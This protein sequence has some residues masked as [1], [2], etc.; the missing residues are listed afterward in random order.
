MYEWE[1]SWTCYD[2]S[3]PVNFSW[4]VILHVTSHSKKAIWE[5]AEAAASLSAKT[6]VN[7]WTGSNKKRLTQ[8]WECPCGICCTGFTSWGIIP[9]NHC[10]DYPDWST[11]AKLN[12]RSK[13]KVDHLI[14]SVLLPPQTGRRRELVKIWLYTPQMISFELFSSGN[15]SLPS[16]SSQDCTMVKT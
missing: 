5:R 2:V 11:R 14:D 7:G 10:T 12:G 4:H 3:T 13:K 9:A 6:N 15:C 1:Y 16:T 8:A